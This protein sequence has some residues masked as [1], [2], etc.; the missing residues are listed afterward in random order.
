[1]RIASCL[2]ISWDS[3]RSQSD[4]FGSLKIGHPSGLPLAELFVRMLKGQEQSQQQEE[5]NK[6]NH[7]IY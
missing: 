2:P 5:E 1:M 3:T 6:C 7:Q 4:V